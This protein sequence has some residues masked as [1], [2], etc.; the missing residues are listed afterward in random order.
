MDKARKELLQKYEIRYLHINDVAA[1]IKSMPTDQAIQKIKA[2][3]SGQP[4]SVVIEGELLIGLYN[5]G[6]SVLYE[7]LTKWFEE[8]RLIKCDEDYINTPYSTLG[9][10]FEEVREF[11]N[12]LELDCD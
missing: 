10:R 1:L 6:G 12:E 2:L 8:L 5:E 3:L 9:D 4:E 7:K 11:L